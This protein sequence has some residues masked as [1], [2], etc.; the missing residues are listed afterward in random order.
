MRPYGY[1]KNWN[2][3]GVDARVPDS[4]RPKSKRRML[5]IARR[6]ERRK[7]SQKTRQ[8]ANCIRSAIAVQ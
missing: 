4:R 3:T 8:L 6:A 2:H 5:R 1:Y 7:A